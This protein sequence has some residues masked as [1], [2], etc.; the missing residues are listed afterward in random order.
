MSLTVSEPIVPRAPYSTLQAAEGIQLAA[1]TEA[2]FWLIARDFG[3]ELHN[4]KLAGSKKARAMAINGLAWLAD[5]GPRMSTGDAG[6][7][8]ATSITLVRRA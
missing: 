4:C 8:R 6:S 2:S 1:F 3:Y 5:A 7:G